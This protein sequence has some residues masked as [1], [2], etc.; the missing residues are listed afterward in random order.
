MGYNLYGSP[1][2]AD[3]FRETFSE[4]DIKVCLNVLLLLKKSLKKVFN[5]SIPSNGITKI[6]ERTTRRA[7]CLSR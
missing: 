2:T 6:W 3:F 1:G 5:R 7:K 4:D